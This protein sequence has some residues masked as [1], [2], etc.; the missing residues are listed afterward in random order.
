[1]SFDRYMPCPG[2]TGKKV[3]FCCED[4]LSDLE[5]IQKMLEGE[6]RLACLEHIDKVLK[7]SPDRPCLL[8]IKTLLHAEMQ[9]TEAVETTLSRF[10]EQHP[11][12]PLAAAERAIQLAEAGEPQ[13]AVLKLQQALAAVDTQMP[14]RV[15][16]A[17]G[18]LGRALLAE[19]HI[20]AARAHLLLQA[21]IGGSE[22]PR[23]MSLLAPL[24]RS[25]EIPLL[26]RDE[27]P[28][29]EPK[30]DDSQEVRDAITIASKG[31]W[32]EAANRLEKLS[33][34]DPPIATVLGNLA[35]LQSWLARADEATAAWKK[36]AALDSLDS[37]QAIEAEAIAQLIDPQITFS[38]VPLIC[39]T[40]EV[41]DAETLVTLLSASRQVEILGG[42]QASPLQ[43]EGQP[44]PRLVF[45]LLDREMPSSGD[46]LALDKMPCVLGQGYLFGRETDRNARLEFV[47]YQDEQTDA[48]LSVLKTIADGNLQASNQRQVLNEVPDIERRMALQIRVP[49]DTP[50]SD[51]E[52]MAAEKQQQAIF[53][54]WP[55]LPQPVL[56]GKT[57]RE[58][59]NE[60]KN[61]RSLQAAILILETSQ[62]A[63]G[64]V[65]DFNRLREK[66]GLPLPQPLSPQGIDPDRIPIVR[67]GRFN[68]AEMSDA[69]LLQ[70]YRR[71]AMLAA[72]GVVAR[73]AR[74]VIDRESLAGQVDKA[75]ACGLLAGGAP[76]SEEA[77]QWLAQAQELAAQENT[78]PGRWLLAELDLR[79][80]Q[81]DATE[82][83]E[84]LQKIQADHIREPGIAQ[85]LFELLARYGIIDP[86][87]VPGG[88]S[89]GDRTNSEDF[90]T[91][92]P[93]ANVE[94]EQKIWTPE[95]SSSSP[96]KKSTIWTPDD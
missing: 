52:Q 61:S 95:S 42:P 16:E 26:L 57:A 19:G 23:A 60:Q 93:S 51:R 92:A 69:W 18:I 21:S 39:D 73:L 20:M 63:A 43:A 17:I 40:L 70:A 56:N 34:R 22:D 3:K 25:P 82:A 58:V 81:H 88:M 4:L 72:T 45:L 8:A 79:L 35:I 36:F 86:Q 28:L 13:Q 47:L 76:T 5:A 55:D 80:R 38:T 33:Q 29:I 89:P 96:Q 85:A 37:D 10:E 46:G 32:L 78:S 15:Y 6:Q 83:Q 1:M 2:G 90:E 31:N 84:L 77:I 12:N 24:I 53:E 94:Q 59:A 87:A 14:V 49:P 41:V 64:E 27:Q 67:I 11:A 50:V 68:I 74:E 62:P 9:Q 75:E 44:P 7:T 66:L 65:I 48:S 91:M 71:A 30:A 54:I